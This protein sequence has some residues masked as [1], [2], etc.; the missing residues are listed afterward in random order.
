LGVAAAA[1]LLFAVLSTWRGACQAPGVAAPP[2]VVAGRAVGGASGQGSVIPGWLLLASDPLCGMLSAV[3]SEWWASSE[4]DLCLTGWDHLAI[5]DACASLS[6]ASCGACHP[7]WVTTEAGV[8]ARV[9]TACHRLVALVELWLNRAAPCPPIGGTGSTI[10]VDLDSANS[11]RVGGV[12]CSAWGDSSVRSAVHVAAVYLG[13]EKAAQALASPLL[14]LLAQ[15]G[16]SEGACF[17]SSMLSA[18]GSSIA[19]MAVR[20]DAGWHLSRELT[21]KLL[22]AASGAQDFETCL[23]QVNSDGFT[24]TASVC[25]SQNTLRAGLHILDV[26]VRTWRATGSHGSAAVGTRA[27][28]S[29]PQATTRKHDLQELVQ[30]A[31]ASNNALGGIGLQW[32]DARS[33]LRRLLLRRLIRGGAV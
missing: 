18:V 32:L 28:C 5:A 27:Q 19:A 14:R 6:S 8:N 24:P 7:S 17:V 12:I 11:E 20:D 25:T 2:S 16:H 22:G 26:M 31:V 13:C 15:C 10:A 9:E 1:P 33:E 29:S 23:T 4:A 3:L 30:L 21:S